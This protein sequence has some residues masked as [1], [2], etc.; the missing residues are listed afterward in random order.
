MTEAS[1]KHPADNNKGTG[2]AL[3]WLIKTT[4]VFACNLFAMEQ[5]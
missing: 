4:S 5:E 3:R 2:L 1:D